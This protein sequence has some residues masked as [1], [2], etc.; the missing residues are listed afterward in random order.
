MICHVHPVYAYKGSSSLAYCVDYITT[1]IKVLPA[2]DADIIS[3][4]NSSSEDVLQ[5]VFITESGKVSAQYVSGYLTSPEEIVERIS[6]LED[7][8]THYHGDAR[9][10][11]GPVG[12]HVVIS[13]A[14]DEHISDQEMHQF[15]GKI[16]EL[17]GYPGIWATHIR[18]VWD[19]NWEMPRGMSKHSHMLISAFP[20]TV[21]EMPYKLDFGLNHERLK[22]LV[23]EL[24]IQ[25]GYQVVID[26]DL[27]RSNTH[28]GKLKAKKGDSWVESA[29]Q[30][31]SSIAKEATDRSNYERLVTKRGYDLQQIGPDFHYSFP[32]GHRAMGHTLGREFT[33]EF[34]ENSWNAQREGCVDSQLDQSMK[35]CGELYVRLPLGG[36]FKK[37]KEH[38]CCNLQVLA[39]TCTEQT[40]ASYFQRG[41]MYNITDEH[42][43]FVRRAEGQQI[44]D[45]L[46]YGDASWDAS[47]ELSREIRK[48]RLEWHLKRLQAELDRICERYTEDAQLRYEYKC[49]WRHEHWD[50]SYDKTWIEPKPGVW[51]EKSTLEILLLRLL[52]DLVPTFDSGLWQEYRL[53]EVQRLDEKIQRSANAL[54]TL[55]EEGIDNAHELTVRT[56]EVRHRYDQLSQELAEIDLSLEGLQPLLNAMHQCKEARD[57]FD[58]CCARSESFTDLKQTYPDEVQAYEDAV[59]AV[60][61]KAIA[62]WRS[63]EQIISHCRMLEAKRAMLRKAIATEFERKRKL[64]LAH[65]IYLGYEYLRESG[66]PRA[67]EDW[68]SIFDHEPGSPCTTAIGQGDT[69]STNSD[70]Q[71]PPS[72]DAKEPPHHASLDDLIR[73]A[74]NRSGSTLGHSSP[75]KELSH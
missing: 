62:Q 18:P 73:G 55:S 67:T 33:L 10:H 45:F 60:G 14:H 63:V 39:T 66:K 38:Y 28:Y 64:E 58:A 20:D 51:A 15:S 21:N 40:L 26:A 59:S 68:E 50:P 47:E 13:A 8:Y 41:C 46:G 34:L 49:R 19:E 72:P 74:G 37:A 11:S 44:L 42:G 7:I 71:T 56:A 1:P 2:T 69:V 54:A 24:A 65:E 23:D 29:R 53:S 75:S 3:F 43:N 4:M 30:E 27:K 22:V 70:A 25:H 16:L 57:A 48:R 12:Y 52:E 17:I 5:E 35:A 32:N 61:Q 36:N 6:Y 9:A 31:L